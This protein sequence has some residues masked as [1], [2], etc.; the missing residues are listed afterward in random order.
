MIDKQLQVIG[1][2]TKNDIISY[3]KVKERYHTGLAE[4]PSCGQAT[5]KRIG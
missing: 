1:E 5:S 2:N 4:K 3:L